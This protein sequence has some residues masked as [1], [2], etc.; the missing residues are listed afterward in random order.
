MSTEGNARVAVTSIV[1][2]ETD[3]RDEEVAAKKAEAD[4]GNL[5]EH[6]VQLAMVSVNDEPVNVSKPWAG[7]AHWNS[8]ARQFAVRAY[9][10]LNAVTK[11]EVDDFLS[12][13]QPM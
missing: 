5:L 8:R 11:E 1:V 9:N 7:L 12:K 6:L 3:G 2:R 10:S 13:A 4:G